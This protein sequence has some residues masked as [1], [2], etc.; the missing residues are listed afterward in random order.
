M[1][2]FKR[3]QTD[4]PAGVSGAPTP[5]N[6]LIW[7]AVIFGPEGAFDGRREADLKLQNEARFFTVSGLLPLG[8]CHGSDGSMESSDLL[9]RNERSNVTFA[10]FLLLSANLVPDCAELL[11]E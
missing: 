4:P 8:I 5:D 11:F 10:G 6:V 3:L 9:A 1:R 7:N 2:D